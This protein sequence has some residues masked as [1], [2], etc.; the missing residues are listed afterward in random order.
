MGEP[1][2]R[3][4]PGVVTL[5]TIDWRR[6]TFALYAEVRAIADPAEA[7]AHWCRGAAAD[8]PDPSG[9][10][11][12]RRAEVAAYDP[13]WRFELP[14]PD[15][16]P[17]AFDYETGTDGVVTFDRV[18]VVDIPEVGSLDVWRHEGY[19]GGI[20]LPFRDTSRATPTAAAATCSTPS[21]APTSASTRRR[22]PRARLQL[23]LQPVVRVRPRVG[24]PARAG[25][26]PRRRADPGRRA[27]LGASH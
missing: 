11:R 8:V 17:A 15:A 22:R 27:L 16:A 13:A 18:G 5:Q 9:E 3:T 10:R 25:R 23:R 24:V 7:H 2:D 19:G 14:I 6:R 1:D 26:R 21:R 20:F 12:G 4:Q